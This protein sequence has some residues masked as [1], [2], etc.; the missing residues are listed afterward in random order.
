MLKKETDLWSTLS[1]TPIDQR[2]T[3]EDYLDEIK[4]D[5]VVIAHNFMWPNL[6]RVIIDREISLFLIEHSIDTAKRAKVVW[7]GLW[8]DVYHHSSLI[9][10]SHQETID[11]LSDQKTLNNIKLT[12]SIRYLSAYTHAAHDWSDE[13]IG[14]FCGRRP[15]LILGS[16]HTEDIQIFAPIYEEIIKSYQLLIVP[17]H[18]DDENITRIKKTLGGRIM[19]HS[20]IEE[21]NEDPILIVDR[22]GILKYLY[23]YASLAYI[24]GGFGQGIHNAQEAVPYDIPIIYGPKYTKFAYAKQLIKNGRAYSITTSSELLNLVSTLQSSELSS[25]ANPTSKEKLKQDV[26]YIANVIIG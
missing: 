5:R 24:G 9:T 10:S 1:Y 20:H 26:A 6:L 4:P 16:V 13:L 25:S 23:R 19:T 3:V 14:T 21:L 22:M 18:I 15:T 12:E 2:S 11:Y 7:A 17:H 8:E